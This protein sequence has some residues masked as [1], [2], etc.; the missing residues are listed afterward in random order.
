MATNLV[1]R[2]RLN[3]HELQG[4]IENRDDAVV[5]LPL[6]QVMSP[7]KSA[8]AIVASALVLSA[9]GSGTGIIASLPTVQTSYTVFALTG[10]SASAPSGLNTYF[11]ST[12]R[13]DGNANFDVAFDLDAAGN[14]LIYPVQK[15]VSSI[16]QSRQV[17]MRKVAGTFDALT[18][19]PTGNYFDSTVVAKKGDVVV[20][21]SLRNGLSDVCQFDISPYIYSKL[22][23]DSVAIDTK[24]I[25]V[26]VV[27][28][29]N[30][31]FRSFATG[32][33]T[34]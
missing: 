32:I 18:V 9:C 23:V 31:G 25:F 11:Q 21:Q 28:D 29:P 8:L 10:T 27:L 22:G 33:P 7:R 2:I 3:C 13:V 16:S 4:I 26:T 17:G 6:M 1:K 24:S 30:C 5:P 19:A 20:I 14:V 15:V 12:E 34:I